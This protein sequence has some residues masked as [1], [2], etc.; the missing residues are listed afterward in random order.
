VKTRYIVIGALLVFVLLAAAGAVYAYDNGRSERI[1]EGV[2]IDKI[3]VG[4]MTVAQAR[5]KLRSGVLEPL[6]QPV[7]A[8]YKGRKFTLTPKAAAVGVDIDGSVQAAIDASRSGNFI[9]RTWRDVTGGKVTRDVPL[10]VTYSQASIDRVVARVSKKLNESA[11]DADVGDLEK[12]HVNPTASK[13]GL[14]VRNVTLSRALKREL[15][16]RSGHTAV[17]VL[18]KVVRPKVTTK[19]L[20]DEYP[21]IILVN[22]GAFKLTLY[23]DLKPAKTYGIAVGQVGLETPAGLYHVQNK[24]INPAWHVPNSD[25][26][27]KLAGKVIPGGV[28]ENPLKARW[29]GIFDGAGIHGTDA[30]GSIGTAASHG[31]IRMRI[32]DVEELYDQVPVGAPVYIA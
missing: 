18:T 20:A 10:R 8:T 2:S 21:A 22:R 9:S 15:L 6:S 1:A 27:G 12:G 7:V 29:L 31:C 24:A 32:P 25:W 13:N 5:A 17:P 3:R 11:R 26:A 19:K 28:P 16:D 14:R 4:G 23:K 30:I